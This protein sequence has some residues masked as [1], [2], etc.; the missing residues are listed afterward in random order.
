MKEPLLGKNPGSVAT[1]FVSKSAP[2][3]LLS[4]PVSSPYLDATGREGPERGRKST[5]DRC[6]PE[7][8][9]ALGMV[10]AGFICVILFNPHDRT[11]YG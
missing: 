3:W 4:E 10:H 6:A 7:P 9:P 2:T 1:G 5:A 8:L 11:T